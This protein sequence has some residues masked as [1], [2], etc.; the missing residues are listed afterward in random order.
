MAKALGD[1]QAKSTKSSRGELG[2]CTGT[3]SRCLHAGEG[4]RFCTR[5]AAAVRLR[6][7]PGLYLKKKGVDYV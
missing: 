1:R 6:M 3:K 7:A 5:D 2:A 4:Q